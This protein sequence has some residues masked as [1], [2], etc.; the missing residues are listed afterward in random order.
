VPAITP[1]I[2]CKRCNPKSAAKV[3]RLNKAKTCP[4]CKN[5]GWVVNND[6][7]PCPA[8]IQDGVCQGYE[9]CY[10]RKPGD[11][12]PYECDACKDV[13]PDLNDEGVC[14]NCREQDG[15]E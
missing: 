9:A 14:E 15:D 10:A 2:A 4:L 6:P 13:S 3:R 11:P 12:C 1:Q 8:M 7:L 5:T